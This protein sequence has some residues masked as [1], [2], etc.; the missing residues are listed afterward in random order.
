MIVGFHYICLQSFTP[1]I[2]MNISFADNKNIRKIDKV[3]QFRLQKCTINVRNLSLLY[4]R[5]ADRIKAYKKSLP[6]QKL[7]EMNLIHIFDRS[8]MQQTTNHL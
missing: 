3:K 6:L 5:E 1:L 2:Q 8:C 7:F 4:M